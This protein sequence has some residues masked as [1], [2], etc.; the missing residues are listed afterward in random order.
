[1]LVFIEPDSET[2]KLNAVQMRIARQ[3]FVEDGRLLQPTLNQ[4]GARTEEIA[5]AALGRK[6][7]I[8]V[9][10]LGASQVPEDVLNDF[11]IKIIHRRNVFPLGVRTTARS[12]SPRATPS[13][14]PQSTKSPLPSVYRRSPS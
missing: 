8:K 13:T 9:V 11:P 7:G 5:L 2:P 3:G 10:N 1:M 12:M 14:S 4:L 6:L